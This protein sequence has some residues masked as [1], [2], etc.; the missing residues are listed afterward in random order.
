MGFHH[1]LYAF[2][3]M[4]NTPFTH[5][6]LNYTKFR[7]RNQLNMLLFLWLGFSIVLEEAESAKK[8]M[9]SSSTLVVFGT[10]LV[11]FLYIPNRAGRVNCVVF[12]EYALSSPF[13]SSMDNLVLMSIILWLKR[14]ALVSLSVA[15]IGALPI[16]PHLV[17]Y[18]IILSL[19]LSTSERLRVYE[20]LPS[21]GCCLAYFFAAS[22]ANSA[23]VSIM[24]ESSSGCSSLNLS[25]RSFWISSSVLPS[26]FCNAS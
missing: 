25:S 3:V 7:S 18:K 16:Q 21:F 5:L 24:S 15:S 6:C 4:V 19:S 17:L 20:L 8:G 14:I 2:E 13:G 9:S 11:G 26:E 22:N 10:S 12:S 23:L 1:V